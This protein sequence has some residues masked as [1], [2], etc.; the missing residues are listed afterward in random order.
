MQLNVLTCQNASTSQNFNNRR[1]K[2][3]NTNITNIELTGLTTVA[4]TVKR[5]FNHFFQ[6]KEYEIKFHTLNLMTGI[7]TAFK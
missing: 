4:S 5:C 7:S 3:S 6:N 2:I 1:E